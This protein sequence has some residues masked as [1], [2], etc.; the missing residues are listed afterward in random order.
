MD[1]WG[2]DEFR[3]CWEQFRAGFLI[4]RWT[5]RLTA[6]LAARA[7]RLGARVLRPERGQLLRHLA[8]D[9]ALP[10]EHTLVVIGHQD[11]AGLHCADGPLSLPTLTQALAAAS[12]E[13]RPYDAV[14]LAVCRVDEDDNLARLFQAHGVPLVSCRG[15]FAYYG[16]AAAAWL[17]MLG[18]LERRGPESLGVLHN[19]AWFGEPELVFADDRDQA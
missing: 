3:A 9:R 10:G 5:A 2:I 6:A 19:E 1:R 4:E 16:R 14:D 13:Q 8:V 12:R 7:T 15:P 11:D 18:L 17:V